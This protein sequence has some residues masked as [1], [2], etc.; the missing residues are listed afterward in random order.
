MYLT[1]ALQK[2]KMVRIKLIVLNLGS[3]AA[4]KLLLTTIS[5]LHLS[6]QHT[7]Q[8]PC[9]PICHIEAKRAW[10]RVLKVILRAFY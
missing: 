9:K 1:L 6:K 4:T 7:W 5:H 2:K 8:I 3:L 10:L